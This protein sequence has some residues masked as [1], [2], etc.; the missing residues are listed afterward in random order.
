MEKVE[1]MG[2]R[3]KVLVM[4]DNEATVIEGAGRVHISLQSN[5][6]QVRFFWSVWC[7]ATE[8]F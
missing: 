4:G 1:F 5:E 8:M 7:V 2:V 3:M 6:G